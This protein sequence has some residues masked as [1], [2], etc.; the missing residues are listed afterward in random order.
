M[1]PDEARSAILAEWRDRPMSD[2]R[3]DWPVQ[4]ARFFGWLQKERSY[5]LEFES[6]GEKLDTVQAWLE[7][8]EAMS[9]KQPKR[10]KRSR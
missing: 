9:A 1:R 10:W 2:R 7:E 4:V 8:Y 3:A 6:E 5:L